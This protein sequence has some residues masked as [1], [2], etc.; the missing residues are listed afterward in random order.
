[1][2]TRSRDAQALLEVLFGIVCLIPVALVLLDLFV[3]FVAVQMNDTVCANAVR[4]A[5]CGAPEDADKRARMVVGSETQSPGLIRGFRLV[6]P[7][8]LDLK[9]DSG[10]LSV[11]TFTGESEEGARVVCGSAT[12][13]TEVEICPILVHRL[14]GNQPSFKFCATKTSPITFVRRAVAQVER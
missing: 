1:M 5:A 6:A 2:R 8:V 9:K 7:V 12:L 11:E 13:S 4:S 14:Y 10:K 3:I